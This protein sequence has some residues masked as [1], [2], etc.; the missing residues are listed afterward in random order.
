MTCKKFLVCICWK[1]I[2]YL[3]N[4]KKRL[5]S[6]VSTRFILA[7]RWYLDLW[8]RLCRTHCKCTHGYAEVNL[9]LKIYFFHS[10]HFPYEY[11]I[12]CRDEIL[13]TSSADPLMLI[14]LPLLYCIHGIQF[15]FKRQITLKLKHGFDRRVS[16]ECSVLPYFRH[17]IAFSLKFSLCFLR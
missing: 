12:I 2:T 3:N 9:T 4:Q 6:A 10:K 8:R 7:W 13:N 15:H 16:N 11:F 14:P 1:E 17:Q 5:Y